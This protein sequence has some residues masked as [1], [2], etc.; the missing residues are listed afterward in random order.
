M[1]Q[2]GANREMTGTTS[3]PIRRLFI[4]LERNPKL[5]SKR[6]FKTRRIAENSN[7]S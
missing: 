6:E 1:T 3:G 7:I 5:N 4:L 2:F